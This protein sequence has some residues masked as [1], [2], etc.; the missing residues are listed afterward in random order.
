[1]LQPKLSKKFC[2]TLYLESASHFYREHLISASR[3]ADT[4]TLHYTK[5]LR[6][7]LLN[8]R[9]R[10][11]TGVLFVCFFPNSEVGTLRP[12]NISEFSLQYN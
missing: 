1:M 2:Q 12:Y 9:V 4:P 3:K 11:R 5:A 10:I 6:N 7:S 8:G